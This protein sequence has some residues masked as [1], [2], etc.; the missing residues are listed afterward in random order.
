MKPFLIAILMTL[1]STSSINIVY[2]MD[3]PDSELDIAFNELINTY[4]NQEMQS[5][6]PSYDYYENYLPE[7]VG[8]IINYQQGIIIYFWEEDNQTYIEI[9]TIEPG[10]RIPS[11]VRPAYIPKQVRIQK[12]KRLSVSSPTVKKQKITHNHNTSADNQKIK[13]LHKKTKKKHKKSHS[14]K[15]LKKAKKSKK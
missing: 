15:A 7:H 1:I 8:T 2:A 5:D 11:P 4:N 13:L 10:D 14:K 9:K 12:K 6:S 3:P